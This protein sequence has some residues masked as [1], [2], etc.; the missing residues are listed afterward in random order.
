MY[1]LDQEDDPKWTMGRCLYLPSRPA[2]LHVV[3]ALSYYARTCC[4][5]WPSMDH[6]QRPGWL[7]QPAIKAR[8]KYKIKILLASPIYKTLSLYLQKSRLSI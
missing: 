1:C 6:P 3:R 2:A 4:P 5:K 8:K 7:S